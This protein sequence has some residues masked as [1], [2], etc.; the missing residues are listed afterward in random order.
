[1]G[2]AIIAAVIDI[3]LLVAYLFPKWSYRAFKLANSCH[4][5]LVVAKTVSYAATS[6]VCRSSFDYGNDTGNH[7]DLWGWTCTPGAA[8]LEPGAATNCQGQVRTTL[9][10]V[11]GRTLLNLMLCFN[12][13]P[14]GSLPLFKLVSKGL[15]FLAQC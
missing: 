2:V 12:S 3:S 10:S 15:G 13:T 8:N 14:H 9:A 11:W 5:L 4:N 7:T 1:L 6:V